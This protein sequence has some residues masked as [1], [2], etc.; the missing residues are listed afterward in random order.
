MSSH[1]R[2]PLCQLICSQNVAWFKPY[3]SNFEFNSHI[4]SQRATESH[5]NESSVPD[6]EILPV[7]S[8]DT[9]PSCSVRPRSN[10]LQY[11]AALALMSQIICHLWIPFFLCVNT[12]LRAKSLIRQ[13]V[14]P[15]LND[16]FFEN[17][18]SALILKFLD[19]DSWLS[20]IWTNAT[21]KK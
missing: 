6:S 8:T 20:F 13:R 19:D 18:N 3:K 9:S 14:L 5:N 1:A 10:M 11:T 4:S 21:F 2:I 17:Q 16:N 12:S 7:I 15:Y